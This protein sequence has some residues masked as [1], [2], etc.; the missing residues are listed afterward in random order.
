MSKPPLP[1][2]P[3]WAR[4]LLRWYCKPAYLEAIEGDLYELFDMRV[5][6]A[7]ERAARSRFVWDVCRFFRWKYIKGLENFKGLNQID[8]WKN[9]FKVSLRSLWR[10]KFFSAINISGLSVGI[11]CCL[12]II[13]YIRHELSYDRFWKDSDDIYRIAI[14]DRGPYSPA[15]MGAFLKNEYP[16][17]AAYTR[18]N[19]LFEQTFVVGEKIIIEP[20]GSLA[21]STAFDVFDVKFLEGDPKYALVRP[22]SVVLTKSL[23]EKY[24]PG[25]SAVGRNIKVSGETAQ[26]TAVVEDSPANSHL[27]FRYL[28]SMPDA[29]WV[30]EGW[31]TGNN[32]FTYIKLQRGYPEEKFEASIVEFMRK[33]MEKDLMDGYGYTN[34]D[35]YLASDDAYF[36]T[37]I[38]IRDIHL[39]YPRLSLAQGSDINNV[40]IFSAIAFFILLIACINFINLS[41][42]KS[43]SRSKEVGVRK[44]LGSLRG[45]LVRQFMVE[46]LLIS[47]FS[48]VL[49]LLLALGVL[50]YFNN[51]SGKQFTGGDLYSLENMAWLVGLLALVGFFAGS[52]PALQL[53]SFSPVAALRGHLK[54]GKSS[55]SMRKV[56]VS[57]QFAISVFLVIA[58]LIVYRQIGYMTT[59]KL[60]FNASQTMV[61][62]AGD[63]LQKDGPYFKS[64]LLENPNI[65]S[66][67][68]S[69][70]YPSQFVG[71]WNYKKTEGDVIQAYSLYTVFTD[72]NYLETLD[73]ELVQGRYFDKS[74]A[75][76]TAAI[77]LNEA[78]VR[79]LG[80]GD[81]IG[82]TLDRSEGSLTV[83]GVVKDYNYSSL[84]RKIYGLALRFD[85]NIHRSYWGGANYLVKVQGNY[86]DAVAHANNVWNSMVP[87]EPFDYDFL[88]EAFA[89]LYE[90]EQKF[91][92]I[93]SVFAALAI[94]IACL[95]LFALAAFTLERRFKEIAI[96]KVLGASV[97]S[98]TKL[99]LTDFTK[100]IF[101]GSVVAIPVAFYLME[102]WLQKFAYRVEL[103]VLIFIAPV[104][105]VTLVAWITVAY[106]SVKTAMSN[107]VQALKQE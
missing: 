33:H 66:V 95:G 103:G 91:G 22:N 94:L 105:L 82:K 87:E 59:Q 46:S 75:T 89:K 54:S 100:L 106:Q 62:K 92:Q 96:R 27:P 90:S 77:V 20:G 5:Q 79:E 55:S 37:L 15:R 49:A 67:A 72:E 57:F 80:W 86:A 17:V 41:T 29:F 51:L 60:G 74:R 88:D 21:D 12:L 13:V 47:I 65:V 71:D 83:I 4:S 30:T 44:V 58:T 19:G 101:Y 50:P 9:Y 63:V 18:L 25:E 84:R 16:E 81:P 6:E 76:D 48:S 102:Q 34:F 61:I 3:G 93:F 42:A 85:P 56:L 78:A 98:I 53:S 35:E 8:M 32:F 10:Q 24:F 1:E 99:V 107:P 40:Y 2:P 52:Y 68:G 97:F 73:V 64:R 45:E 36:F 14:N 26:I 28:V 39:H 104:V 38:P 31:W 70:R 11:A 69:T 43:A 23:A 7:G